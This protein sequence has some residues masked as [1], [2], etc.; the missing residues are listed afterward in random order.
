MQR[1][2]R[3]RWG[4]WLLSAVVVLVGLWYPKRHS[5]LSPVSSV[6]ERVVEA[7]W[8]SEA[9]DTLSPAERARIASLVA[10]VSDSSP[11]AYAAAVSFLLL[12]AGD[13]LSGPPMVYIQRLQ[14]MR[15]DPWV[16]AYLGRLAWHTGQKEK[17]YRYLREAI[18]QDASCGPAYLFLAEME[19][20]S[21]CVWLSR[22][23]VA[24]FPI[25]AQRLRERLISRFRCS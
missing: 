11:S 16:L 7:F 25:G 23:A 3:L 15:E 8:L 19:E 10:Q 22:A 17:A 5:S 2:E 9:G 14:Q 13:H 4:L 6:E 18:Q 20:D 1:N 21:A 24:T 12:Y